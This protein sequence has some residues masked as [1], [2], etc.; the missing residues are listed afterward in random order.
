ME[1][2]KIKFH[3]FGNEKNPHIMLIH[4]GGN[5]WWNYLRQA[6]V[7]SELYYVILPTLDGHGEEYNT[8]FVSTEDTGDKLM[9]YIDSRCGGKLFA[10]CGVSIGGQI[11]IEL[12]SRRP[13]LAK[14]A[15]IDGSI[16]YPVPNLA[17]LCI[18]TVK[19][20]GKWLFNEK[21][22][23]KQINKMNVKFPEKMLFPKEIQEY[24]IKDIS[25]LRIKTLE[26]IYQTYMNYQLKDSLKYTKADIMYWYGEKEIKQVKKS[27]Q[28]F[29]TYV[30]NCKLYEAK[31][32]NHGYL[33]VYLPEEWI[34]LASKFFNE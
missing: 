26:N 4:G 14:K 6:R 34:E 24:Y 10:L 1:V 5:A 15:I 9:E 22:C 2:V 30:P 3:E 28:I 32:Y 31:G 19:I 27:A 11:V 20:F 16:C 18:L 23:K 21:A 7:L 12:L 13:D 8:S 33:A 17:K 25:R 29:R